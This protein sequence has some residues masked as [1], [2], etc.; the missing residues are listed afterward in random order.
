LIGTGVFVRNAVLAEST[1]SVP[2]VSGSG[3]QADAGEF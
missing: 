3:G 1:S 2:A